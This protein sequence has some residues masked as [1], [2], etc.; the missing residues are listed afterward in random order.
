MSLNYSIVRDG[1]LVVLGHNA[2]SFGGG[3]ANTDR[4]AGSADWL[5]E[6]KGYTEK[7][8]GNIKITISVNLAV[9]LSTLSGAQNVLG[10]HEFQGHGE[11]GDA[12]KDKSEYDPKGNHYK[13]Y[14]LQMNHPSWQRTNS[15]FKKDI[16]TTYQKYKHQTGQ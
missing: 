16:L 12:F 4:R 1:K 15:S 5:P 3:V 8:T 11:Q 13:A 6:G 14:D 2:P 7:G 10:A 9:E